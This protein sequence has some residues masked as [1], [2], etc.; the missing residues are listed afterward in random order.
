MKSCEQDMVEIE[1]KACEN[2]GGAPVLK[3]VLEKRNISDAEWQTVRYVALLK[4]F[5]Y[6]P[7]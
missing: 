1:W 7:L 4:C 5:T 3:Y 6:M 2:D